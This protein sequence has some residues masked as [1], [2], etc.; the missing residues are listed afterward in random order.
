MALCDVTRLW[1]CLLVLVVG[2]LILVT[3][4]IMMLKEQRTT[5]SSSSLRTVVFLRE[6]C[7]QPEV[8]VTR[9]E[10]LAVQYLA[11]LDEEN[12]QVE[13][14]LERSPMDV[15]ILPRSAVCEDMLGGLTALLEALA[16]SST[17]ALIG[18]VDPVLCETVAKLAAHKSKSF[19]TWSC[20]QKQEP[21]KMPIAVIGEMSDSESTPC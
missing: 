8:N 2:L 20:P 5:A 19:V 10:E 9:L 7:F 18:S 17:T 15:D 4:E 12:G 11:F 16:N 13:S 14:V 1:Y 3:A 6:L 21:L